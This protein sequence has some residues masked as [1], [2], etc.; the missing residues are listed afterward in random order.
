MKTTSTKLLKQLT[1]NLWL[2]YL[3]RVPYA[4][5]YSEMVESKGGRVVHDHIAFRTLNTH[6]GE[7]P[8]GIKAIGHILEMLNYRKAG[9]Y[10]FPKMQVTAV[11]YEHPDPLLPRIFV[12]QLEV[13]D[14]PE[15]ARNIINQKVFETPYLISDQAIELLNVIE[16]QGKINEEAAEILVEELT[17]YFRRPWKL[18]QRDD[19][20]QI[21]DLSQYA[22]WVLL[23]GNSVNHFAASINL[24]NVPEWPDLETTCMALAAARIP[25]K[26][27]IEG[28]KG[29]ILRQSATQAVK[30]IMRLK[31]GEGTIV[32]TE[33]TY[34]YY[35][36]TERGY[37]INDSGESLFSG[38]LTDQAT[39]LFKMTETRDN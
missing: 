29:S 3:R 26:E 4:H 32:D 36:F 21:N 28:E 2:Q 12:S 24:Q 15:W 30:E 39:H 11:H 18:P 7:Q 25:M 20:L 33:W 1:E 19:L 16:D 34:A 9:K 5:S 8:S 35:E 23:H 6:T 38:F 31:S 27:E 17:G 14:L 22:A 10:K 37:V 13:E